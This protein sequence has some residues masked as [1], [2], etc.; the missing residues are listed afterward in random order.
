MESFNLQHKTCLI[1][2]SDKL[3]VLKG[4]EKHFL[5]RS[6]PLGFIFCS[7]IPSHKELEEY[8]EKYNRQEYYSPITRVRFQELL[9]EM[10]PFRKTNKILDIGCGT[11]FFLEEAKAMGWEVFGTEFTNEAIS[12]CKS[13]GIA[14]QKGSLNTENYNAQMFDIITS[15]EVIEHIN[16]PIEEVKGINKILRK[17]GLVYVTT[18]NFNA[19]ERFLLKADYSVITYPEHLSYYTPK[20]LNYLFTH[21]GFK[22]KKILT[23]GISIS[24]L[25]AGFRVKNKKQNTEIFVSA[26]STDELIRNKSHS[27]SLFKLLQQAANGLLNLFKIGNSLKGWFINE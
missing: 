10:E 13:K 18:P 24:R 22:K 6:K 12:I 27:N 7:Q 8:Y 19:L 2:G 11:G 5:V 1:S 21:N 14:M 9:T 25:K 3:E 20:T 4:Y 17:G 16:N 23:T 26:T 15:F